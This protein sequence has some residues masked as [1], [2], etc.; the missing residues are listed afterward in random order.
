MN[1]PECGNE[2]SSVDT[3]FSTVSG[4]IMEGRQTGEIFL[5]EEC[6]QYYI[7]DFINNILREWAY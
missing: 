5:C 1:C 3:T 6:E 7:M 2:M 4:S